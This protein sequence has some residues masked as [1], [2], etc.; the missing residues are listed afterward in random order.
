MHP[1]SINLSS[2]SLR[3]STSQLATRRREAGT[4]WQRLGAGRQALLALAHLRCDDT[5]AKLAAGFGIGIATVC[6]SR[7]AS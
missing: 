5:Y 3:Y 4:R 1:S 6:R 7:C 2:R